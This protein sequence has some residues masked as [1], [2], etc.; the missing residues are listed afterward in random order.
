[1]SS[2]ECYKQRNIRQ[3]KEN[4]LK[5]GKLGTDSE[6]ISL[7]NGLVN[8]LLNVQWSNH[9]IVPMLN[10]PLTNS[11]FPTMNFVC[12]MLSP[13]R[14]S[15]LYYHCLRYF[16]F[17]WDD[18]KSPQSSLCLGVSITQPKCITGKVG[19]VNITNKQSPCTTLIIVNTS[20]FSF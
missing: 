15:I 5:H 17:L 14:P 16:N 4:Y 10:A 13:Q 20:G 19:V 8:V 11:T 7:S 6:W 18:K 2:S 9:Q 1:M 12:V 3:R